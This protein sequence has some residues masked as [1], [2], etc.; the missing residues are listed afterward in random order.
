MEHLSK[1]AGTGLRSQGTQLDMEDQK[2]LALMSRVVDMGLEMVDIAMERKKMK[3]A[4]VKLELSGRAVKVFVVDW[5]AA[6]AMNQLE[7]VMVP[8]NPVL[9]WK[10]SPDPNLALGHQL[11]RCTF[12][13]PQTTSYLHLSTN[14]SLSAGFKKGCGDPRDPMTGLNKM[15][16]YY[17]Q[18]CRYLATILR[19]F[20]IQLCQGGS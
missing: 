12:I 3:A 6:A 9:R 15:G 11:A 5:E 7:E 13:M 17:H 19:L 10:V 1:R 20:G 14:T 16:T 2:T 18:T 4:A 8:M